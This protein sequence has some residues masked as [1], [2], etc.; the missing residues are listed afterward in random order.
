MPL[1]LI[2]FLELP[3]LFICIMLSA[4]KFLTVQGCM[5]TKLMFGFKFKPVL[6]TFIR[7]NQFY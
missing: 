2:F 5:E 4:L 6:T 1:M 7:K 3:F